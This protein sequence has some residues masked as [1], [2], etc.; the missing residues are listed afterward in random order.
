MKFLKIEYGST[1]EIFN[2]SNIDIFISERMITIYSNKRILKLFR[3]D[4]EHEFLRIKS[5]I[6]QQIGFEQLSAPEKESDCDDEKYPK[7][8]NY[9]ETICFARWLNCEYPSQIFQKCKRCGQEPPHMKIPTEYQECE[10]EENDQS[11]CEHEW[12][13]VGGTY[14][15]LYMC[16]KCKNFSNWPCMR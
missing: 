4:Y 5:S 13:D 3:S 14:L 1:I 10:K 8:S 7:K 16:K 6:L 12:R 11:D 15:D 9:S 2:L